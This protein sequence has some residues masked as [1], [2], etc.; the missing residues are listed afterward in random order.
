[1]DYE[2]AKL[3]AE[4]AL[5]K[6]VGNITRLGEGVRE[7]DGTYTFSV[8]CRPAN[9]V[10]DGEDDEISD[11]EYL[12]GTG[13]GEIVVDDDYGVSVHPSPEEI[14]ENIRQHKIDHGVID[15]E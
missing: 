3:K 12:P 1:M 4:M 2:E 14:S 9:I 7:D 11:V 8:L 15:D 10:Y 5:R 6:R 13:V